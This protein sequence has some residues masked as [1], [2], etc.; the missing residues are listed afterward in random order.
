MKKKLPLY[1]LIAFI[2]AN[3]VYMILAPLMIMD[4]I[5]KDT[6]IH[7]KERVLQKQKGGD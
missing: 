7:V 1:L 5:K 4:K 3:I 2:V 6:A